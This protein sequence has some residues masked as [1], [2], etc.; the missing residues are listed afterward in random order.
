[1]IQ[2]YWTSVE[3]SGAS[4]IQKPS[5]KKEEDP[6]KRIVYVATSALLTLLILAPTAVAQEMME[7][8]MM[9]KDK[10]MDESKMMEK[11]KMD[12]SK[13]MEKDKMME[14]PKK[15][16]KDKKMEMPKTGGPS[17]GLLLLP[18]A[19]LLLGTGL[20]AGYVVRRKR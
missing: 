16:E 10:M 20:V 17:P 9:E 14:Q 5:R 19:A 8:K 7:D 4:H 12:E 18:A 1:V 2:G 11:D 6:V 15:M 3:E 13:M